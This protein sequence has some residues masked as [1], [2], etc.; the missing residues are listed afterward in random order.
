MRPDF[1]TADGYAKQQEV[2][3]SKIKD[4]EGRE[5]F[6]RYG[7]GMAA[8]TSG[9]FIAIAWGIG[10]SS[11]SWSIV[12]YLIA[13]AVGGFVKAKEGLH[14]LIAERDLDVNL[15][16]IIAAIGAASIGY[17]TEGAVLIFIFSFS[18]ALETYT[19]DR[20]SR[21]ISSL[22][23]LK[24][25]TAVLF[26]DG[27]ETIV[28]IEALTVG[29]IVLI[30]PGERI[31]SD[32]VVLEGASAVN[33]SSITGESVPVD[34]GEG[35]EVFAGTLNGQGALFIEV[36][37]L[38]ESTLFAKIIRLV[39]EAQSEK[40]A[41]QLFMER[42]ERIYAKSII[43]IC[44]L[45]IVVPPLLFHLAWDQ[46]FYKAMVFLV[47]A[48]PCALVASIMPAMLSAISNGARK[49]LLFKGGAH[50][51]NLATIKAIA[52]DKTGTLTSGKPLVT[53]IL[54]FQQ[55]DETEMLSIAASLESLSEHPLAKAIVLEAQEQGAAF[56]RPSDFRTLTGW[57][58]QAQWKGDLWKI[59]KPAFL[60]D[61][62]RTEELKAV[63]DRLEREGKT[64]TVMHNSQGVAGV[65][66][67]RDKI[68]SEA[69]QAVAMLKALGVQVAMLTGDQK[70]T[71]DAIGKELGIGMVY[72]DLLPEDKV[73]RI[74]ELKQTFGSIAMVGD[75]VNDAPA[76]AT[77]TVG[78][79]MGVAGSDAALETA[80]LVLMNDDIGKIAEAIVLGKRTKVIIKQNI[81][82]AMTIIITLIAVNFIQGIALPLGVVGHEGSTI[83]VI[84]NGLRLLR[85]R[86][87]IQTKRVGKS[88]LKVQG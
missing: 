33:Q 16:M 39:Q 18:G 63:I 22:M 85:Q 57:G 76:L 72:A 8:L 40:P 20:S 84:L 45:L 71:A 2:N 46:T 62:F 69:K 36:S 73:S 65:I 5:W 47:V 17:W 81:I 29:D 87:I 86:E 10:S 56:D 13:F 82:F 27:I 43:L 4:K 19:M 61:A 14:T 28:A 60:D 23:D 38:S 64:V 6:N 51:E 48:S 34:K 68:R 21:D 44:L 15:L 75:G 3:L 42:F 32:G 67:L 31:P 55:L 74:K 58:V 54:S 35:D 88:L 9:I 25:E 52:F 77:A 11:Q 78:V 50:L 80:D 83:L 41:S 7:E 70:Q 53:D 37:Q 79:A 24:P 59:G 66:A 26:K 49:G 12:F 30:K 1:Q